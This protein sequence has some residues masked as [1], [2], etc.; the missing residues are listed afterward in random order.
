MNRPIFGTGVLGAAV[1]LATAALVWAQGTAEYDSTLPNCK[2]IETTANYSKGLGGALGQLTGKVDRWGGDNFT[3]GKRLETLLGADDLMRK[4]FKAID[5][6]ANGVATS[7]KTM[8]LT[9][10]TYQN[11]S[12]LRTP[13]MNYLQEL[14]KWTGGVVDGKPIPPK[15]EEITKRVLRIGVRSCNKVT[16]M[17]QRVFEEVIEAA[18]KLKIVVEIIAL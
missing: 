13:L 16:P 14:K 5:A 8:D 1:A 11:E 15:G 10:G 17:Q 6:Y 12:Y 4:N 2:D 18:K 3:R 7:I 9:G